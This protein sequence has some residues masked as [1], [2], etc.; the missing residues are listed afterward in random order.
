MMKHYRV[1]VIGSTGRGNYGHAL[2][3]AWLEIPETSIV[4]VADDDADGL[5]MA[6]KRLGVTTLY[7]DY[8]VKLQK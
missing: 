3:E 8:S 6:S 2:D 4:A 1:A 5:K 7:S